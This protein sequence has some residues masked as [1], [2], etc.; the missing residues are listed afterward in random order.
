MQQQKPLHG[1]TALVTGGALRIGAACV[2]ALAEAGADV[3]IHYR[4]SSDDAAKAAEQARKAAVKAASVQ[5]DLESEKETGDIFKQACDLNGGIDILVNS[6]SVF[7]ESS[8]ETFPWKELETNLRIN[9][10]SPLLL[11][12]LFAA[13]KRFS[14]TGET[15]NI[16]NLLDTRISD[17]DK[18]HAAYHLSKRMLF[19]ITRMLSLELAPAVKVNAIAPGLILPP[20]G[21]GPEYLERMRF[22]NPLNRCGTTEDI[23]SSLLFLIS[24]SFITG[25]TIYVD[26]GRRMKG[27][28]YGS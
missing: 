7:P 13:Q 24:N 10:W 28:M 8:I 20:P 27:S 22:T 17:Y 12:R 1:K 25:Q 19:D 5:G 18:L 11:S 21:E 16:I 2:L 26:G 3:V 14:D 9:A 6:A 23:T 15:G 4:S